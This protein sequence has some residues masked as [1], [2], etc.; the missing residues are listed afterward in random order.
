MND[1]AKELGIQDHFSAG[2]F[3]CSPSYFTKDKDKNISLEFRTLF[4]QEMVKH[5][6]LIPWVALSYSHGDIELN[7]TLDAVRKS[8]TVYKQALE[9]SVDKHLVGRAIKPVFRKYN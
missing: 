7:H 1:V 8:L 9:S 6:V 2:G 4:S 5:G 3:G